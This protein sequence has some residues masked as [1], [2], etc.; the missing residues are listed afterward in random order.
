MAMCSTWMVLV[1]TATPR[2]ASL[3]MEPPSAAC[4]R[5]GA[6]GCAKGHNKQWLNR[7]PAAIVC[8]CFALTLPFI[9]HEN[10]IHC[11]SITFQTLYV[12]GWHPEGTCK[13]DLSA[14]PNS[15]RGVVMLCP[16]CLLPKLFQLY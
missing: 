14:T 13:P 9:L 3:R 4:S 12:R 1:L 2:H 7:F 6:W 5:W 15:A 10:C 8:L 11:F 16:L